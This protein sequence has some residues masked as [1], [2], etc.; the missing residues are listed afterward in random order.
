MDNPSEYF[1]LVPDIGIVGKA[2]EYYVD[3]VQRS[4]LFIDILRKR[5]NNYLDHLKKGQPP[6]LTFDYEVI[7]DGRTLD[8]PVNYTLV[9][10]I[11]RRNYVGETRNYSVERRRKSLKKRGKIIDPKKQPILVID[12]RAGNGPGIG[13][14]KRDSEI[15]DALRDGHP[16]YFVI[17]YTDPVPGQTI[18]DVEKAEVRFVEEIVKRHPEAEKPVVIGNCQ[19]GWATALI[20]ADRPDTAGPLILNG[21]PLSYW[22]GVE[23]KNPMRYRGGLLGGVWSASFLSDLGNGRF[24]GANLVAGFENLNPANTLWT[25]QYNL[26][27]KV[28]TEE[29]RYLNFEKWWGGFYLMNKEEMHFIVDNLFV[30]DKLEHGTLE[31]TRGRKIN[32]RNID[33]PVLV[34]TSKGDNISPPQ[35][36]LDWITKVYGSVDEIK[37]QQKVLIYM[38]HPK[39]GHLGIFVASSVGKKEHKEIIGDIDM[40][41]YLPPGLYEMII[42]DRGEK[43]GMPDYKVRFEERTLKDIMSLGTDVK[44]EKAFMTVAKIS[45]LNDNFYE[46]FIGPWVRM[47]TT[48]FSAEMLRQL[49]PLR[50]QR[51]MFSDLNPFLFPVKVMAQ[52][53]RENRHPVSD[54]NPFL[55]MQNNVSESVKNVLDVY[56]QIRDN[57]QEF[58]FKCIYENSSFESLFL[59][60]TEEERIRE[61]EKEERRQREKLEEADKR[62]WIGLMEKG[63]FAEGAIR[64]M[65]LL[66]EADHIFER[67][68][69][70]T[71][72]EIVTAHQRLNNVNA[73]DFK[74]MVKEQA[75]IIQT[76]E[77]RALKALMKLLPDS[78][79]RLEAFNIARQIALGKRELDDKEKTLLKKIKEALKL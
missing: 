1:N 68:E 24:D 10:I 64:I 76:D 57:T 23:G 8:R 9:H 48:E 5:G 56:R 65:L 51:Y 34:F 25:K 29:E 13:G 35:Q 60:Q 63:G 22:A 36:A 28:D 7:L 39:I 16:V 41:E 74:R 12:P 45:R 15:G 4:I 55:A 71:C 69:F 43:F 77:E 18:S 46:T 79:D 59:S 6:V 20:G 17:F 66:V 26:Y 73:Q 21:A 37:R 32:L 75:R 70:E 72:E 33:E 67:S 38:V 78:K 3:T 52:I 54:D 44:S 11:D 19:A 61:R 62:H 2:L 42:E 49:H 31:L 27:S 58:I 14:S 30:G 50:M 40:I 47:W 53:V